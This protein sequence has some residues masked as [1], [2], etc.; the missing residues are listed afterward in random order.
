[1]LAAARIPVIETPAYQPEYMM[2]EHMFHAVKT[3][4][5]NQGYRA[6]DDN[7]PQMVYA[8]M[9]KYR[10]MSFTGSARDAGYNEHCTPPR[11]V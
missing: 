10:H 7:L 4:L 6:P 11:A 1:M 9:F 8:T 2:A 3:E 5:R